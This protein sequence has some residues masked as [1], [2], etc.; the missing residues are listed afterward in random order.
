M[1]LDRREALGVATSL[2][3][4]ALLPQKLAAAIA[5]TEAPGMVPPSVHPALA[6]ELTARFRWADG[7]NVTGA[8]RGGQRIYNT[9][10]G[11]DFAGPRVR[12]EILPG[13]GDW[14]QMTPADADLAHPAPGRAIAYDAR[15][16]LRTHDGVHIYV[17]NHG[18]K[19]TGAPDD[20]QNAF[21]FSQP[22][23]DTP[24]DSAYQFLSRAMFVGISQALP[25]QTVM[26]V[27]RVTLG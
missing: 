5:A 18:G 12:G 10:A 16:I 26:H 13:G 21:G 27:F 22:T 11:G 24:L 8:Y 7:R 19:F 2:M 14:A 25:S 3:G 15:Y 4:A 9:V 23:F 20:P 6:W 1:P 17:N